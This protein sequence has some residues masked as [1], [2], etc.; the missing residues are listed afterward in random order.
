MIGKKILFSGTRMGIYQENKTIWGT[1]NLT[2]L[3]T[4]S[5]S[6]NIL[7]IFT[8]NLSNDKYEVNIYQIINGRLLEKKGAF[9]KSTNNLLIDTE[10]EYLLEEITGKFILKNN[11]VILIGDYYD[12]KIYEKW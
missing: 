1:K 6:G 4:T 5:S 10:T 7:M 2:Y 12:E 11:G 9:L 8:S 3:K